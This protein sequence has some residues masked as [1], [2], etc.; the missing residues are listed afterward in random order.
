MLL[1]R[2][3]PVNQCFP[4]GGHGTLSTGSRELGQKIPILVMN[5]NENSGKSLKEISEKNTFGLKKHRLN[6]G[7]D[8]FLEITLTWTEKLTQSE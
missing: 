3:F 2:D 6:F 4:T 1:Q 5:V 7:E 8:V